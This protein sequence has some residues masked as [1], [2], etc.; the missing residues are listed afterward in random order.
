MQMSDLKFHPQPPHW[1]SGDAREREEEASPAIIN[2]PR[3]NE[4]LALAK[5]AEEYENLMS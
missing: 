5:I 4:S 1:S 3:Q 2:T